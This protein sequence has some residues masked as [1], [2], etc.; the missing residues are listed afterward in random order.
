MVIGAPLQEFSANFLILSKYQF[1]YHIA[2]AFKYAI[3]TVQ[4]VEGP[5]AADFEHYHNFWFRF[6]QYPLI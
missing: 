6:I 3:K 5:W 2:L 4:N 1:C